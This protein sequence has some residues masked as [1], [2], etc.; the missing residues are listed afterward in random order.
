MT[1]FEA[2]LLIKDRMGPSAR[3]VPSH[4]L[5]DWILRLAALVNRSAASAIPEIGVVRRADGS[6]ARRV[7]GWRPRSREDAILATAESL[8]RLALVGS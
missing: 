6:K 2:A 3:H 1:M 5:P 8:V 4:R 7:L